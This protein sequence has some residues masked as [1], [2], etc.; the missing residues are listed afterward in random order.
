MCF[1]NI[2]DLLKYLN[3]KITKIGNKKIK[4]SIFYAKFESQ[5]INDLEHQANDL[6]HFN[7]SYVKD[8]SH[9]YTCIHFDN[10]M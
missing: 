10:L 2:Y 4:K 1:H 9:I 8:T 6:E 3:K 7:C 5:S